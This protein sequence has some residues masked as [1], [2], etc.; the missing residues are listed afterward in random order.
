MPDSYDV[1]IIGGSY[2]GLSAAMALGRSLRRTL[3][4]DG[5]DPCNKQTPAAHNVIT[6]DGEAPHVI[7]QA[8]RAQVL[9]YDHVEW[10]SD[11]ATQLSGEDDSFTLT[12]AKGTTYRGKKIVFATGLHDGLPDIPGVEACW[13]KTVIH[14]PYC[15]G[16][17]VRG[18][19]TGILMNNDHVPFMAR[20]I[21][22]LTKQLTVFSNGPATFDVAA[23][24]RFGVRVIEQAVD[25]L[26]HVDGELRAVCLADGTAV[27]LTALYVHPVTSQKCPLPEAMGCALDEHG[28]LKVDDQQLTTVPGI[29]GAGDCT[30]M[31]RSVPYATGSGNVT[32]AMVNAGLVMG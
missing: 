29:Y 10:V 26:D 1:L 25:K 5:G 30:T 17:E 7:A 4:I 15:H 32:G 27:N 31:M 24:E 23:V 21:G 9:S 6:H 14:C 16:Y 8:A 22:N 2:A 3:I 13:G 18:E 19:P 12:T 20:L 11:E 28:F